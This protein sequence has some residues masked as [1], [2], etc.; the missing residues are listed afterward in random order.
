MTGVPFRRRLAWFCLFVGCVALGLRSAA[1]D[2]LDRSHWAF[3]P[4]ERPAVPAVEDRDWPQTEIDYFILAKLEA[5]GLQPMPEANRAT[6]IRRLTFDLTGLPPSPE[7]TLAFVNDARPLAYERLV[8]RLLARPAYGERMAQSWLDLARFAETDGFEHDHVRPEAWRYR[9]WVIQAFNADLPY[10]RFVGLQLAGDELEPSSADARQATAFC[11]AGPDMPDINSQ[12]ERRH[13]LLNSLTSTVGSV[14]L[15]MQV[16]CAQCHDHKFDPVSQADFYS[17]RAVFEPSVQLKKNKSVAM[18]QETTADPAPSRLMERGDWR[19]PGDIVPPAFLPIANP[20]GALLSDRAADF[21]NKTTSGR[22]SAFASWLMDAD[23][24]LPARVMANRL[25][26]YHFGA[27]L[28]RS[29]SD[30]GYLS[31]DPTHPKLL[32]WLADAFRQDGWSMKRFQRRLV[33]SA[34]YRQASRDETTEET[35]GAGNIAAVQS[36]TTSPERPTIA[37]RLAASLQ[38]D[39][40]NRLLARYP[41]RRLTGEAV[42]DAMLLAAGSLNRQYGG[43]SVLPPLPPELTSTLL[44]GQWQPT[45]DLWQ[46]ERRSIYVFARRNLR[47]PIFEAFDRPDGN[48]S[49]PRRHVSTTAP[50][51]LLMLNSEFSRTIAERFAARV[52]AAG[53]SPAEQVEAAWLIAF[54]RRPD[55]VETERLLTFLAEQTEQIA[56]EQPPGTSKAEHAKSAQ[57]EAWVDSC[58]ALLNT[59]PFVY[60]D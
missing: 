33:L 48:E 45:D 1:G 43:E 56:A 29:E 54:H 2:D 16:G 28:C 60:L 40:S 31:S 53:A 18:L 57:Q 50:Q 13:V 4:I 58:L 17:L 42:R 8:D 46:R 39:P 32:D 11:V 9:D 7:E 24:P 14:F 37:D 35:T 26:Q 44:R 41:R 52:L 27:G 47:Y 12:E 59:S 19:R 34:V 51:S 15:G 21:A 30:F 38:Q 22:R 20:T 5:L 10:D 25:W 6:L 23:N 36:D 55:A 49:C 3:A